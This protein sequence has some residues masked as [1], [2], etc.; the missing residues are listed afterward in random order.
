VDAPLPHPTERGAHEL[1]RVT[2]QPVGWVGRHIRD[3]PHRHRLLVHE[4]LKRR[5]RCHRPDISILLDDVDLFG[6]EARVLLRIVVLLPP[7][8]TPA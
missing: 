5:D 8:H 6:V 7:L 1:P 3:T 2:P 4:D